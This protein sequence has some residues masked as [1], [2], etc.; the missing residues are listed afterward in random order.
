[1][2]IHEYHFFIFFFI[3]GSQLTVVENDEWLLKKKIKNQIKK[4]EQLEKESAIIKDNNYKK[5]KKELDDYYNY[6]RNTK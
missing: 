4:I 5:E 3:S 1:M 6:V 2:Q